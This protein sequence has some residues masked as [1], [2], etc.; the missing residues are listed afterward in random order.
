MIKEIVISNY[1]TNWPIQYIK[2]VKQITDFLNLEAVVDIQHFGS[3]AVFGL[4]AKPLID[5]LV[6]FKAFSVAQKSLETLLP[7]NYEYIES[8]SVPGCRLFLKKN[9]NSYH[10]HFVE[11]GTDHWNNPIKFR[12]YIRTHQKER[13]EYEDLKKRNSEQFKHD[14]IRYGNA[15]TAFINNILNR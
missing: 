10:L 3:T 4:A 12:D 7:L 14:R 6:G 11:Y 8:V 2:E 9:P 1:D 5:I 13:N 15:K